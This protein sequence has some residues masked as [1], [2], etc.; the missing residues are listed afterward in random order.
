MK[1]VRQT[2]A[3]LVLHDGPLGTVLVGAIFLAVGGGA[4]TLWIVDPSGWSGN[5]GSWLVYLVGGLFALVG[6]VML[7]LSADR[8]YAIDRTA[9]TARIIVQGLVHRRV[10]EFRLADLKDVALERSPS[11]SN[12][13]ATYRIVFLTRAGTR[14]PWTPFSTGDQG[15]LS[16]CASTVRAFCG[17]AGTEATP[18][19]DPPTRDGTVSGHPVA[20]SWGCLGAFFAIFVA[21]GLGIFGA[22][23]LRVATWRPVSARI[24][25]TDVKAI[26]GNKGVSYSP[27]VRY[28]YTIAGTLYS[29]DRVL[30]VSMSA[31][32]AWAEELRDRFQAGQV[33]TAYVNPRDPSSAFLVRKVSLLPLIFVG[34]PLGMAAL[35]ALLIRAQRRQLAAVER[36]PVP[37]VDA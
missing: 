2:P 13:G 30:P 4:I 5:G 6:V 11:T 9:G 37:V 7:S 35:L 25:S 27:V 29:A 23:V 17:W 24:L 8:R 26:R 14:V 31:S 3:E 12:S 1:V 15:N 22:E 32:R 36:Y 10:N 21:A 28:Q 33:V 16:A 19:P 18:T 34:A 20:T